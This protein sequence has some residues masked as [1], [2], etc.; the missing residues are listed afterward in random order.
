MCIDSCITLNSSYTACGEYASRTITGRQ[1][2]SMAKTTAIDS[3][4]C[5][6]AKPEGSPALLCAF[7]LH[8]GEQRMSSSD[9]QYKKSQIC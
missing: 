5:R 2:S 9:R 3:K 1:T 7:G 4:Q 6:R 8:L